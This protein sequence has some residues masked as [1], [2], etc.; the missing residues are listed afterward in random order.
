MIFFRS[1]KKGNYSTVLNIN[2]EK[3]VSLHDPCFEMLE[4]PLEP[5]DVDTYNIINLPKYMH[6]LIGKSDA[7]TLSPPGPTN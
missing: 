4:T 1:R 5:V 3:C 2:S 7:L 6:E